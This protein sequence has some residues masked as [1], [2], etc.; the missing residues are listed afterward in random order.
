MPRQKG[1]VHFTHVCTPTNELKI[2][3]A[4]VDREKHAWMNDA[5]EG[6]PG[7]GTHWVEELSLW[8]LDPP[9][10][11]MLTDAIEEAAGHRSPWCGPCVQWV[12]NKKQAPVLCS[13]WEEQL[14]A[15]AELGFKLEHIPTGK[16]PAPRE[17]KMPTVFMGMLKQL[18]EDAGKPGSGTNTFLREHASPWL[19]QQVR[20]R[21]GT[22]FG[23]PM[24]DRFFDELMEM[25]FA[26]MRGEMPR[27]PSDPPS[28]TP[29]Q[30]AAILECPWPCTKEQ[31]TAAFRARAKAT[32][33]D[34]HPNV[35]DA[36]RDAFKLAFIRAG[37][38]KE[39]LMK[40][41]G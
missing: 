23:V 30:A 36:E 22:L 16:A 11:A 24:T 17:F 35:T 7:W 1:F 12:R 25:A 31:V 4:I 20:N 18:A 40:A 10:D 15:F 29:E 28:M 34:M 3:V 32:H 19:K 37:E 8:L 27:A 26:A 13:V 6:L 21:A 5:I 14:E 38:A 33:P 41:V 39:V 2:A 9:L